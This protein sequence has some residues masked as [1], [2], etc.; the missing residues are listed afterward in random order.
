MGVTNISRSDRETQELGEEFAKRLKPGDVVCLYGDLGY[1]K[2]TFVK[3]V[4][5]GLGVKSRIISPTFVIVRQHKLGDRFQALGTRELVHIDLYRIEDE[6]Q[7]VGIGLE[8]ILED[9]NAIKL[10]EWPE[11]LV[12][13]PE[14]RID[15]KFIMNKDKQSLRADA[16]NT[17]TITMKI[18]E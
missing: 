17:R 5:R 6:R 9:K 10:I 16:L 1:G 18:Y 7:L 8:D 14:K 12:E 11:K 4:A 2:T 15:I 13:L 3:G